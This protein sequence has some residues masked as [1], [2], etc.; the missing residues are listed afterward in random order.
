MLLA[1]QRACSEEAEWI[2][3]RPLRHLLHQTARLQPSLFLQI[4]PQSTTDILRAMNSLPP[5][6]LNQ[7][8]AWNPDVISLSKGLE[9]SYWLQWFTETIT[10]TSIPPIRA[11]KPPYAVEMRKQIW[12]EMVL[13]SQMHHVLQTGGKEPSLL[14]HSTELRRLLLKHKPLLPHI[15]NTF[16]IISCERV[17]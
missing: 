11:R 16:L 17:M 7:E 9:K 12:R 13:F 10:S 4:K 2:M 1:D 8:S 15:K 14:A 6:M 5:C 3:G